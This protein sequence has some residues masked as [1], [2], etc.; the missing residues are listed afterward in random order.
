LD[1]LTNTGNDWLEYKYDL[2]HLPAGTNCYIR[3]SFISDDQYASEGEGVYLDDVRIKKETFPWIYGD[4]NCDMAIG[5]S[6]VVLVINY[7]FKG[8]PEPLPELLAGDANCDGE[9]TISDIIYLI[10]YLFKG[11]PAP[12]C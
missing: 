3:F 11:G 12:G 2:S 10:N 7:L 4:V 1:S 9:V 6:D 5:I 8:G